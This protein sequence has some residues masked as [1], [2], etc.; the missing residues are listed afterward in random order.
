MVLR[1]IIKLEEAI[2]ALDI[3]W[4]LKG[5]DSALIFY[6]KVKSGKL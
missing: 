2:P 4:Y 1:S 5:K 3:N 6:L